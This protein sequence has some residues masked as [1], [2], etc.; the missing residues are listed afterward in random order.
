VNSGGKGLDGMFI[1]LLELK[2][3]NVRGEKPVYII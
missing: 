3:N 1:G 2:E